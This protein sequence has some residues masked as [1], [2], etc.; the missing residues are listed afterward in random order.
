ME[1]TAASRTFERNRNTTTPPPREQNRSPSHKKE[2]RESENKPIHFTP[3]KEESLKFQTLA[4]CLTY[5]EY[6]ESYQEV[7]L[8]TTG[9]ND[10]SIHSIPGR[11]VRVGV[12]AE[13]VFVAVRSS[14][15]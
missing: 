13:N 1:E 11:S 9:D 6:H 10:G 2:R 4:E 12:N 8:V 15:Q 5:S 7:Y 3:K 14:R